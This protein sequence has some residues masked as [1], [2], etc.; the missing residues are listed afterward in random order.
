VDDPRGHPHG[1]N[2]DFLMGSEN[3]RIIRVVAHWPNQISWS[4][5]VFH[6]QKHDFPGYYLQH[7][8]QEYIAKNLT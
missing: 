4:S 7:S 5:L 1:R 3:R 6:E 2:V 8:I